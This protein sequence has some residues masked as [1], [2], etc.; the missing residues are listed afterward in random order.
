MRR[1]LKAV[2]VV[3]AAFALGVPGIRA[4]EKDASLLVQYD[5]DEGAGAVAK[6]NSGNGLNGQI[7][8][9]DYVKHGDGFA[10]EFKGA[11]CVLA[12]AN[13]ALDALGKPGKSYTVEFWFKSPGAENPSMSEKWPS[14]SN[15]P[16]AIRGPYASDNHIEFAVYD[17]KN[18]KAA[19]AV[20]PDPAFKDNAWHHL[21]AERDAVKGHLMLFIDGVLRGD[22]VDNLKDVDLSNAGSV[23]IGARSCADAAVS[24]GFVGQ[25]DGFR[26]Y[27]RVLSEAEVKAHAGK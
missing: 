10:L 27:S 4:A 23:C 9:A 16:W 26:V 15:Y 17:A 1:Q 13:A 7:L 12:P 14:G 24:Y 3:L 21:A 18:N 25:L 22:V 6:D 20:V 19:G 2:V 8:K 11:G 5:F